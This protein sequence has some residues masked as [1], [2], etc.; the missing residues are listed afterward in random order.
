M[1]FLCYNLVQMHHFKSGKFL[2][3]S[4]LDSLLGVCW[5][6][7][8]SCKILH[9]QYC[10]HQHL[11]TQNPSEA[12]HFLS[13]LL[14]YEAL[15]QR[16]PP[17]SRVK[18]VLAGPT[19]PPSPNLCRVFSQSSTVSLVSPPPEIQALLGKSY[20]PSDSVQTPSFPRSFISFSN[21]TNFNSY[22]YLLFTV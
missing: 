9:S 3:N 11:A 17:L 14:D 5:P 13:P 18:S 8:P 20:L 7:H 21:Y 6:C 12:L 19:S 4:S 10:L 16:P 2:G 15:H 1:H 22:D